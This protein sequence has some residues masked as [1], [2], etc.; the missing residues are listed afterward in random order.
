MEELYISLCNLED[1]HEK[2]KNDL[3]DARV[4]VQLQ[5]EGH[6]PF[7]RGKVVQLL[8][9]YKNRIDLVK[10]DVNEAIQQLKNCKP[11]NQENKQDDGQ[12]ILF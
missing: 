9:N 12:E 8:I 10:K 5:K 4:N 2:I 1:K 6:C 3:Y 7:N 11:D